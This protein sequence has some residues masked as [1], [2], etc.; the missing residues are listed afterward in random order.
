MTTPR[1][2]ININLGALLGQLQ[3]AMQ[4]TIHLAALGLNAPLVSPKKTCNCQAQVSVYTS[5]ALPRGPLKRRG[6]AFSI[7]Y[8]VTPYAM[9]LKPSVD[10]SKRHARCLRCGNWGSGIDPR[11]SPVADWHEAAVSQRR[12]FHRLGLPDKITYLQETYRLALDPDLVRHLRSINAARNCL[13][14]R[15]GIVQGDDLNEDGALRVSWRRLVFVING[16]DGERKCF[17][18]SI[19]EAGESVCVS[20]RDVSKVFPL[21]TAISFS[22]QEFAD[23]CWSLFLFGNSTTKLIEDWARA[24][25]YELQMPQDGYTVYR[26]YRLV[27]QD[28]EAFPLDRDDITLYRNQR[29]REVMLCALPGGRCELYSRIPADQRGYMSLGRRDYVAE[30]LDALDSA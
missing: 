2:Q 19:V 24:H 23:V 10:S 28:P 18:G 8:L 12:R 7:G 25:G 29:G 22:V 20:N 26:D 6:R 17:P 1:L 27:D 13:V 5:Q 16:A 4:R 14:H 15:R 21:G 30:M 3:H 9:P 11:R